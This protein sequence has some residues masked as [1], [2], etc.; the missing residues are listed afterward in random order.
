MR[1]APSRSGRGLI[2]PAIVA[3]IAFAILISL[4]VWQL[5]RKAWKESLIETVTRRAAARPIDLPSSDLWDGLAPAADEFRRVKFSAEI[6]RNI[7][8]Y[9]Y[10]AG[11]ALR[12]DIKKPGYYIF[13]PVR[14]P[15]GRVVVIN[16]GFADQKTSI[17]LRDKVDI[18]GYIRFPESG[19]AFVSDHDISGSTWYVRD[20]RGM[21]RE[22]GW[23][24][25]APFYIDM[26]SS[27]PTPDIPK[28]GPLKVQ[29]RNDHLGYA[30]T[31]FGLAAGL[32]AVFAVWAAARRRKSD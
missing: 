28:P 2:G 17:G 18:V 9:F 22:L 26:E 7:P 23:G 24:E 14:L 8:A 5:Q 4:G 13:A 32:V 6:L 20:H 12:E 27:I 3:A 11:S 16:G 15:N 25:T 1:F 21:A 19:N 31:W 30:L 29:L 10:T